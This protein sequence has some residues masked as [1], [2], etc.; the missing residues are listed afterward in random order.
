MDSLAIA[1]ELERIYPEPS[2]KFANNNYAARV[3][4]AVASLWTSLQAIAIPRVPEMILNP[5]SAEYFNT[6]REKRFGMPLTE[7]AK[8]E[9]TGEQAWTNVEKN[10]GPIKA[11]LEEDQGRFVQ[12]GDEPSF[13]DF[14]LAGAFRLLEIVDKEGDLFGRIMK[15]DGACKPWLKRDD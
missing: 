9:Q 14:I 12:G 10:L 8:S 4:T 15:Y 6:T 5:K 7:L 13:A 3:Q 1:H 2:L 11:L